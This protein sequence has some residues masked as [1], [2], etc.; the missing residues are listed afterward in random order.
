MSPSER[1]LCACWVWG[2]Y[3]L[4]QRLTWTWEGLI[5]PPW[6]SRTDWSLW[7][8]FAV[9]D[10]VLGCLLPR[11]S[12]RLRF[13]SLTTFCFL[14]LCVL[15]AGLLGRMCWECCGLSPVPS[16]SRMNRASHPFNIC[17]QEAEA[18]QGLQWDL[19]SKKQE[20]GEEEEDLILVWHNLKAP[21]FD[22]NYFF[23]WTMSYSSTNACFE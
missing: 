20:E 9:L 23:F 19:V 18:S 17:T 15:L 6:D 4:S 5:L 8:M 13:V 22:K 12:L 14:S 10:R 11:R 2:V 21:G 1:R 16:S 3:R 7:G